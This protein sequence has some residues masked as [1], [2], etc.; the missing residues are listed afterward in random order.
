MSPDYCIGD[1]D[2]GKVLESFCQFYDPEL[3]GSEAFMNCFD[4]STESALHH[5]KVVT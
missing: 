2:S 4:S 5:A 1:E 3:K